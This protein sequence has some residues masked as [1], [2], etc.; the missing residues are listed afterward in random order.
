MV[1]ICTSAHAVFAACVV[2]VWVC[3]CRYISNKIESMPRS[4]FK[5]PAGSLNTGAN[6]S[7]RRLLDYNS[8]LPTIY[9]NFECNSISDPSTNPSLIDIRTSLIE[10]NGVCT[11][12]HIKLSTDTTCQSGN[13]F[14]FCTNDIIAGKSYRN[15]KCTDL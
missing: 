2:C 1:F 10:Q 11:E 9:Y 12:N 7:Q 14:S 15:D 13:I 4:D 5:C 3:L 6:G 8:T